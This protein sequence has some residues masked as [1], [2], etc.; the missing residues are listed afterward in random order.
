MVDENKGRRMRELIELTKTLMTFRT[1]HS[2]P[3]EIRRCADFIESYLRNIPVTVQRMDCQGIPSLWVIPTKGRV[4]VLLMSHIDVVDA[5]EFLFEPQERD[6]RLYGRGS[7]DDKYAVALS[8]TLLK[9]HMQ[10]LAGQGVSQDALPF[11]ILI[12]GDEEVGGYRGA[13]AA[14]PHIP[15]DFAIALDG[16]SFTEIIVKEKGI[17]RLRLTAR[18]KTAHGARPWLGVNA[19]EILMEDLLAVKRLFAVETDDHWHRTMNIG[20]VRGGSSINQVPDMAE[21]HLDI[22]YTEN[23]DPKAL[24]EAVRCLVRSH[25]DVLE[26]EPLFFGEAAGPVETSMRLVPE[27]RLGRA[28]GASDARFLSQFG[29]PGIVWGADGEQ[30]QHA[31]DEHVIIDS[32][33]QLYETLRRFLRLVGRI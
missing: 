25:V 18:G 24:V 23:D 22:R 32:L 30:S 20:I 19:I 2:R 8:M 12:T 13:R 16:G 17:V 14:L 9:E 31:E 7:I 10:E 15:A 27:V 21:A 28:H 11:G 5:P 3:E 29:I 33:V 26:Q 1:M 6:G 4:P